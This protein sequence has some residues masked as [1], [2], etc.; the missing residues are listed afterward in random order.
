MD[1]VA[2]K[3]NRCLISDAVLWR[4]TRS[5]SMQRPESSKVISAY[6]STSASGQRGDRGEDRLLH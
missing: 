1:R 6:V 4:E 3:G 5:G 2:P